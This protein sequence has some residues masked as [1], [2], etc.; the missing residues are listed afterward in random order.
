MPNNEPISG[1]RS[2]GAADTSVCATSLWFKRFSPPAQNSRVDSSQADSVG[3]AIEG[4]HVGRDAVVDVVLFGVL[5]HR[6]E[7]L[8]HDLLQAAV[9]QLFVP[10]E[11]LAILHPL[12]IG[13]GDAAGVGQDV[14]DYEDVF[15]SQDEVGQRR[16]G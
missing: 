3:H 16:S 7:T 5:N 14:G 8:V 13:D 2:L 1:V 4:Q 15:V 11:T 12:E 6:V 10:E 9:H